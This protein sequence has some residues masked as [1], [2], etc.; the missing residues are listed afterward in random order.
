LVIHKSNTQFINCLPNPPIF[1]R[2]QFRLALG[3]VNRGKIPRSRTPDGKKTPS[4]LALPHLEASS[5]EKTD[6]HTPS[7]FLAIPIERKNRQQSGRPRR[8]EAE[9]QGERPIPEI[10]ASDSLAGGHADVNQHAWACVSFS[11]SDAFFY[12]SSLCTTGKW[13]F[14]ARNSHLANGAKLGLFGWSATPPAPVHW[15]ALSVNDAGPHLSIRF[16]GPSR[17]FLIAVTNR[18]TILFAGS[19]CEDKSYE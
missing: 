2:L 13:W 12:S 6:L 14:P 1:Q 10:E 4:I 19:L 15:A 9:Y 17:S 5:E 16:L 18:E 11:T 3:Q 8:H 7:W